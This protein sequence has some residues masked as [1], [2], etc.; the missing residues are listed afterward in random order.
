MTIYP[1]QV[2]KETATSTIRRG[3]AKNNITMNKKPPID[4]DLQVGDVVTFTNEYGIK[5]EGLKVIGFTESMDQHLSGRFIYLDS[6]AWWFPHTREELTLE[7]R[8]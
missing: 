7:C 6:S 4:C 3:H 2:V 5:F 1:G 8:R